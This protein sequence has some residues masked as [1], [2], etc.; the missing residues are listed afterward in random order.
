MRFPI[1]IVLRKKPAQD[2][3]VQ[4]PCLAQYN[5]YDA[6]QYFSN[7]ISR[8]R[9]GE[10]IVIAYAGEPVAKLVPFDGNGDRR[11]GVLRAQLILHDSGGEA[12]AA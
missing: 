12:D 7:L 9:R 10:Q 8:V 11:P 4:T 1:R 5:V 2:N 3:P 6:R